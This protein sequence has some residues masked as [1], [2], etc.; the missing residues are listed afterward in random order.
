[1]GIDYLVVIMGFGEFVVFWLLHMLIFPR[2]HRQHI[3]A[4]F[5]YIYV[6]TFILGT[7]VL[8]ILINSI[9]SLTTS[10]D[11]G[12]LIVTIILVSSIFSLLCAIYIIG[13]FGI[14]E[15]S[16]RMKL[17]TLVAAKSTH[18]LTHTELTK[19]YNK[20]AD[21]TNRLQRL[22]SSGDVQLI[23]GKYYLRK[24]FSLSLL[25][26]QLSQFITWIYAGSKQ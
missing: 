17:L 9:N 8:T 26:I 1:M 22:T 12:L 15:S 14:I 20:V 6:F 10:S 11:F 18:G 2:I 7:G 24:R 5:F 19:T 3:I 16:V 23:N 21:L 13:I 25:L 4:W